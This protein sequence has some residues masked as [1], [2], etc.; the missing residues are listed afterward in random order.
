MENK[1]LKNNT[2]TQPN[3]K[4][5]NRDYYFKNKNGRCGGQKIQYKLITEEE[6]SLIIVPQ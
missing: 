1:N 3:S 4:F 5:M 2:F 6:I